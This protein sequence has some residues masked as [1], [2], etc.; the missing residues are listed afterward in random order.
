MDKHVEAFIIYITFLLTMAIH[1][2]IKTQ[3]ALLISKK[4][5]ILAKYWDFLNV[6]L[7]EKAVILP[8]ATKLN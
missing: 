3:I 4:V 8:K 6:F 5:Q 7:E 2:A 1:P